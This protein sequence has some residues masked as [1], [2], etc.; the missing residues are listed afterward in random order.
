MN[1]GYIDKKDKMYQLT[2]EGEK[3]GGKYSTID[4]GEKFIVWP[5]TLTI[6]TSDN[7]I[8]DNAIQSEKIENGGLLNSTK[9]AD[10][11][12]L[13]APK[14]NLVLSEIGWI[15][16]ELKGWA[17]TAFGKKIG[18]VELI[19][20]KSRTRYVVW[21]EAILNNRILKSICEPLRQEALENANLMELQNEKEKID[22]FRNEF[23]GTIRTKDGHW[24]R[25]KAEVIIDDAL[26][27]YGVPHAYERR[28][29]IEE[30]VYSDFYLPQQKVYIEYWGLEN[31]NRYLERKK[32]KLEIYKK[33]HLNLIE[34]DEVHI[35]NLDDHLPKLLLQYDIRVF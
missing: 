12:N 24:V 16:K 31:N 7:T 21:P 32:V 13:A 9:I 35:R 18:G 15:E 19:H 6:N 33:Y 1:Q 3:I 25:S 10:F 34:L 29:P 20:D 17:V 14:I 11:F 27:Y 30:D 4:S 8:S 23:P 28:I 26:Y 22:T 5:E 2:S